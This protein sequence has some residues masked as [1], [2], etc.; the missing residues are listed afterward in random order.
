MHS[1]QSN[2]ISQKLF[3]FSINLKNINFQLH[4]MNARYLLYNIVPLADNT[5]LPI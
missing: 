2:G 1:Y 5:V 4:K 3:P